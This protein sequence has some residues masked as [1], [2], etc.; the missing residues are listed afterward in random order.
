MS[1]Q[2]LGVT[3]ALCTQEPGYHPQPLG[4]GSGDAVCIFLFYLLLLL[5]CCCYN[6]AGFSH[7]L[8]LYPKLALN[9]PPSSLRLN[10]GN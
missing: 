6:V 3:L 9:T 1:P 5:L 7:S 4:L 8:A 2:E 10:T